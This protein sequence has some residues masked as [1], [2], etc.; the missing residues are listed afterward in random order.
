MAALLLTAAVRLRL[1]LPLSSA[2]AIPVGG[3]T[4]R[5]ERLQ[6]LLRDLI[7]GGAGRGNIFIFE[8]DG[9]RDG[10]SPA[11]ASIA[12]LWGVNLLQ[13]HV[14]RLHPEPGELFGIHL[15]RHYYYMMDTL[16]L[17]DDAALLQALSPPSA[18]PSHLGYS[19]MV[20]LED[21]LKLAPDAVRFFLSMSTVMAADNSLLCVCAHADNAFYAA[22]RSDTELLMRHHHHAIAAREAEARLSPQLQQQQ[23]PVSPQYQ[24]QAPLLAHAAEPGKWKAQAGLALRNVQDG[25]LLAA[26]ALADEAEEGAAA[27]DDDDEEA[28]A[29]FHAAAARLLPPSSSL[30]TLSA[31]E[32]DFRRG[33]H[34][35][36][37]GW[38]TSAA[39]YAGIRAHWF[40]AAQSLP[41]KHRLDM[42]NGNWDAFMDSQAFHLGLECIFPEVP[43]VAHIGANGYTVSAAMQAELFDNLRLSS[44]PASV[45]YGDLS[46]LTLPQYDRQ[47]LRFMQR[48]TRVSAYDE[49]R[50]YRRSELCLLLPTASDR[51]PLWGDLFSDYLGLVSIGGHANYGKQRGIHHGSVFVRWLSNLLLVVGAHG[52]LAAPFL[53]LHSDAAEQTLLKLSASETDGISSSDSGVLH[54][55]PRS[56]LSAQYIGCYQDDRQRRLL[57]R[58]L[59]F[60]PV[61]P[62]RC[63]QSCA[64]RGY[65]LAAIEWGWECWCGQAENAAAFRSLHSAESRADAQCDS[66][67][68][69][70]WE[71]KMRQAKAQERRGEAADGGGV[72]CGGDFRLSVYSTSLRAGQKAAADSADAALPPAVSGSLSRLRRRPKAARRLSSPFADVQLVVADAGA[73]CDEGCAAASPSALCDDALLALIH[74]DCPL[75]ERLLGC[76]G[77]TQPASPWDGFA[78]PGREQGGAGG[79]GGGEAAAGRE[80]RAAAANASRTPPA[81]TCLLSRGKYLRCAAL[82]RSPTF[83]RAC[84]C[85]AA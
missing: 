32:F 80:Q 2:A 5:L 84:A 74:D 4:Q 63:I 17:P 81:P 9:S 45:D 61:T 82:P 68:V 12:R 76:S 35:M 26:E 38:M 43:R 18:T 50:W 6:A 79:G 47:L 65:T 57:P 41:F 42:P 33:Q 19:A 20:I 59:T 23:R 75:M 53:Q 54:T 21:D 67:C 1:S 14:R 69:R 58:L 77:C 28:E 29:G 37:P 11:L 16:L 56:A 78:A 60:S 85:I 62:L 40:D 30:L 46:R 36:A 51:D 52:K 13:S 71:E 25:A 3:R 24:P 39:V 49:L 72:G 73:S 22:T 10:P 48:C 64:L 15:A 34:F 70:D 66:S 44:L 8:D 83:T 31:A 55:A 7:A 27:A